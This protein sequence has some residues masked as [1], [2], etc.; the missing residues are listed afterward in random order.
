MKKSKITVLLIVWSVIGALGQGNTKKEFQESNTTELVL[1]EKSLPAKK[2]DFKTSDLLVKWHLLLFDLIEQT[3]G[4]TPNVAARSLAYINLA[5]YESIV[6]AFPLNKS[7]SGQIDG[8]N[9]PKEYEMDSSGFSAPIA[10]NNAVYYMIDQLFQPAPYIWMEKATALK[11]SINANLKTN[12]FEFQKSKNFGISM[13]ELIFK[14]A[15]KDGGHQSYLRSYDLNYKLAKCDSCFEINRVA[16]LENTGPLHPNWGKNRTFS[17][18][19]QNDFGISPTVKFSKYPDSEF[20]KQALEVYNESKTVLPN[21]KKHQIANFWDDAATYT[22][23]APGHSLSILSQYYREK[24]D[25][26]L[27]AAENYCLLGMAV[28]DAMI[29]CWKLKYK[30]NLIRPI[31][32][33]KKYIDSKWEATLL[34]PPF[35]EFPSGHSA[36]SAAMA[37]VLSQRI[38]ANV[39]FTDYSKYWVGEPKKFSSFWEAAN[40]TSISRLYGGIHFKD[41]LVQGQELGKLIGDNILKFNFKK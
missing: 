10:L 17:S 34:T 16:D 4:Y 12:D 1:F 5:A 33:I 26:L 6:P 22:Y 37:K 28:N 29:S 14:F 2:Y 3:N 40:E 19:N 13:A 20:Y 38:G 7:L 15:S 27:I 23:T 41:A 24:P 35:P 11:D 39:G 32:Y 18:S 31:A 9:I 25:S 36:Q 30:N 8:Y 21:T